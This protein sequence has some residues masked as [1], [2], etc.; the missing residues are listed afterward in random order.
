MRVKFTIVLFILLKGFALLAQYN[1]CSQVIIPADSSGVYSFSG[2]NGKKG[3]V[4]SL[5]LHVPVEYSFAVK[6]PKDIPQLSVGK[7]LVLLPATMKYACFPQDCIFKRNEL[8]C[9][10]LKGKFDETFGLDV[11]KLKL[12][13]PDSLGLQLNEFGFYLR[14]MASVACKTSS[15]HALGATRLKINAFPN[16]FSDYIQIH[17]LTEL[18]GLFDLQLYHINGRWIEKRR[19]N[20]NPGNNRFEFPATDIPSGIY[21]CSLTDGFSSVSMRLF[22]F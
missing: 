17:I 10:T 15:I 6:I 7:S 20:L 21:V 19:I 5:C 13:V 12:E 8:G 3:I 18:S 1:P 11:L 2:Y 16:P 4:D 9:I 14:P 22:K